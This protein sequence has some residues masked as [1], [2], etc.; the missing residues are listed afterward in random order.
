MELAIIIWLGL[1]LYGF[2]QVNKKYG[3]K[4][5]PTKRGKAGMTHRILKGR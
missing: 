4:K 2:V 1:M 3:N 5:L